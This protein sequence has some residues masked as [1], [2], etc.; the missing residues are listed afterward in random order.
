MTNLAPRVALPGI[1]SLAAVIVA[2]CAQ[3]EALPEEFAE[4]LTHG[5][6]TEIQLLAEQ[7]DANAQFLLGLIYERGQSVPQDDTEAF[8]WF[9][10]AAEQGGAKAQYKVG[11]SYRTG[12]GVPQDSAEAL[13]WYQLAAEQG[14]TPAQFSLGM[15]YATGR[16]VPQNDVTADMWLN[17]AP[18][19]SRWQQPPIHLTVLTQDSVSFA[20]E[21]SIAV[22]PDG[23]RLAFTTTNDDGETFLSV[24]P[25]DS[26]VGRAL[27]DTKGAARPFW[28][29]D[30]NSVGFFADGQLKTLKLNESIAKT[31]CGAPQG[32]DATWNKAGTILFS[33]NSGSPLYRVPDTG[34]EP[35]AVTE[36]DL[37]YPHPVLPQSRHEISHRW[38]HFLPDDLHFIYVSES[39]DG[40]RLVYLGSLRSN[41]K[42]WIELETTSRVVFVQPGYLLFVNNH[43]TLVARSFHPKRLE[44][45]GVSRPLALSTGHP[46]GGVPD[47]SASQTGTLAYWDGQDVLVWVDQRGH[48]ELFTDLEDV[49]VSS[50]GFLRSQEAAAQGHVAAQLILGGRYETGRGI[51]QDF[52]QAM[53]WYRR[54]A[55]RRGGDEAVRWFRREALRGSAEAQTTLGVLYA[56]GRGVALDAAEA[57][58]YYR[59]AAEQGYVAALVNLGVMYEAGRG[60]PQDA[61]EAARWYRRAVEQGEVEVAWWYRQAAEDGEAESRPTL[62]AR[63]AANIGVALAEAVMWTRRG[64]EQ[65]L[66]DAQLTLGRMYAEGASVAPDADEAVRWTR[67]AAEQGLAEA[68]L[69]LGGRYFAG[70]GVLQDE[71]EGVRWWRLAAEQ[72]H[73]PAQTGLG[74]RYFDGRGVARD[75]AEAVRWYRMAA[76]QGDAEVL[77][78]IHLTAEAGS[79]AAQVNLAE[80]YASGLGVTEDAVQAHVWF[81]LAATQ[82]STE[83]RQ[84]YEDARDAVAGHMTNEELA[85]AQRRAR[86][87]E[88]AHSREP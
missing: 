2:S 3:R 60:V 66:A 12:L 42:N 88:D 51:A 8:R 45:A 9:R 23:N 59:M 83:E 78:W 27:P 69:E 57:V 4:L 74:G 38:P 52:E 79:V 14:D 76:E 39:D 46:L 43:S 36:L 71:A 17:L 47:F 73:L 32:G 70:R 80:M 13:Q 55:R 31:L 1:L 81:H 5:D 82:A 29:P 34:G 26:L 56:E 35:T 20:R 68:Q 87:W 63:S 22:S 33:L 61:A 62:D 85:D 65:G 18:S 41:E 16:G 11:F 7:G 86:A 64:A 37:E 15:M 77:R 50:P 49:Y 10:L 53:V 40:E 54:A 19:A 25:L 28:S 44:T 67:R 6:V 84:D 72:G 24:R 21:R 58:R 30:S 75:E 48:A